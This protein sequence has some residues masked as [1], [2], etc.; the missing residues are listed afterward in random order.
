MNTEYYKTILK[1]FDTHIMS[2]KSVKTGNHYTGQAR[3]F[4]SFLEQSGVLSLKRVNT[5]IMNEY[6]DFLLNRPKKRGKGTLSVGSV[7]DNF[8]T[9]RMLS[10]RMQKEGIISRGLQVPNN[11]KVERDPDNPFTLI[12][13]ILTTDELKMVFNTCETKLE[14]ALI[15]LAYGCGLRRGTLV[16]LTDRNISYT[17]GIVTLEFTK[18]NKTREVPISDFFLKILKDYGAHRIHLLSKYESSCTNFFIDE[19]A[20]SLS[21]DRLNTLLKKVIKRTKD[22]VLIS[23]NITLH[24]LRHSIA[25]HLIDAGETYEYVR[26]FLGHSVV[27][28]ST[29]YAKRRKV[30]DYY[31]L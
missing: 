16:N 13:Q 27:D 4:L 25:T 2:S 11:I 23:K 14:R 1:K 7:N 31:T 10:L 9:L 24:C 8:S 18:G 30:K 15:A 12:R 20:K 17:N 29:I 26:D 5:L 28:T 6:Y 21:G 22:E 19:Q 3:E